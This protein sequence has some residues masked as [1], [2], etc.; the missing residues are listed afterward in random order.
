MLLHIPYK[1]LWSIDILDLHK[2]ASAKQSSEWANETLIPQYHASVTMLVFYYTHFG[3]E[4]FPNGLEDFIT[5]QY[6]MQKTL[7]LERMARLDLAGLT[8]AVS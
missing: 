4:C 7:L 2:R 1:E 5:L 6:I 8:T 3:R